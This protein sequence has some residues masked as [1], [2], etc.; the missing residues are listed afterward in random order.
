[1][2]WIRRIFFS[3]I[4]LVAILLFAISWF[5]STLITKVKPVTIE[6]SVAWWEDK[7]GEDIETHYF[8]EYGTPEEF[9]IESHDGFDIE[10]WWFD[11][12]AEAGCGV[13]LVHGYTANRISP[14]RYAPLF[15]ERGCDMVSFDNRAHGDSEG[16]VLTFGVRERQ[17]LLA[18][19]QFFQETSGLSMSQIGW[20]G[21]SMGA[22]ISL[23]AAPFAP[24]LAFVMA[25]SPY[26]DLQTIVELQSQSYGDL[27]PIFPLVWGMH[28]LRTGVSY[29]DASPIEAVSE[30]EVP[31]FLIHSE[32]DDYTPPSHSI[33]LS[34]ELNP[35]N[36]EF[37]L[38]D[39]G[40]GHV[41]DMTD[42]PEKFDALLDRFITAHVG[43]FGV[44]E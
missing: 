34:Q 8:A 17:D 36:S 20:A 7:W 22:A 21:E 16:R 43:R 10:G 6:D 33:N 13:V 37:H 25:D 1:M 27:S 24:D 12:P 26:Q 18:V 31:I 35:F 44:D 5:F 14:M 29:Q 38:T 23:Q 4:L 28:R 32:T 39:W 30:I 19:T 2:K 40:S 9:V 41:E 15:W 42:H 11:H 3:L